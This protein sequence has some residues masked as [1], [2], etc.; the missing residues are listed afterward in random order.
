[1][2]G[3]DSARR[4]NREEKGLGFKR[5]IKECP[6]CGRLICRCKDRRRRAE[7]EQRCI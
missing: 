2:P 3:R 7:I 4:K 1:M 6:G 5:R